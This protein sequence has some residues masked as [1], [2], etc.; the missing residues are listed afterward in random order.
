MHNM[1]SLSIRVSDVLSLFIAR[2]R[3]RQIYDLTPKLFV[4]YLCKIAVLARAIL[5]DKSI[6]IPYAL[7]RRPVR[8]HSTRGMFHINN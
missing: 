2:N 8:Y 4:L 3:H 7:Y 5:T 1:R 6:K